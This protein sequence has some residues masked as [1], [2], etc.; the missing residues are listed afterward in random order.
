MEMEAHPLLCRI[1]RANVET[2]TVEDHPKLISGNID[3][4]EMGVVTSLDALFKR[5]IS[6]PTRYGQLTVKSGS[7]FH[8]ANA[9]LPSEAG[10]YTI[11]DGPRAVYV[12]T[13]ENLS[14]R[15]NSDTGS[16]DNFRNSKRKSD[17]ERNIIKRWVGMN[18]YRDLRVWWITCREVAFQLGISDA[19]ANFDRL[20]VEKYINLRKGAW[21]FPYG[22]NFAT[23]EETT[24]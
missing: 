24:T 7:Y 11:L 1:E 19:N 20:L 17:P 3:L 16:T 4:N 10:W 6:D 22:S 18:V 14:R 15:L 21:D 8:V 2:L 13:A 5:L 12:G 23:S 9:M